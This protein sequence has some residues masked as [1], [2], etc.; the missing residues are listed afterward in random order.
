MVIVISLSLIIHGVFFSAS[1]LIV[2][3]KCCWYCIASITFG[4]PFLFLWGGFKQLWYI[5]LIWDQRRLLY[6]EL[7]ELFLGEFGLGFIVAW[8]SVNATLVVVHG[9]LVGWFR[10]DR[11]GEYK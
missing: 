10:R 1:L 3:Y 7:V 8:F 6:I 9:S 5:K 11:E 2:Y 4:F